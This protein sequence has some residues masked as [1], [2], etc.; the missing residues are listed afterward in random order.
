MHPP[1]CEIWRI[2]SLLQY[3]LN[4]LEE[5][6]AKQQ[7]YRI[8]RFTVGTSSQGHPCEGANLPLFASGYQ[9]QVVVVACALLHCSGVV[10]SL[11]K[12]SGEPSAPYGKPRPRFVLF[13]AHAGLSL[14]LTG[15]PNTEMNSVMSVQIHAQI[16]GDYCQ[17]AP[18]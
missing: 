9:Q 14:P 2:M 5:G 17:G 16:C 10:I 13:L 1:V 15:L 4:M 11:A 3:Y 6:C 12:K 7:C 8:K 18:W